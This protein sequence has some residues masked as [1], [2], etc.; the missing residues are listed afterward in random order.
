[1]GDIWRWSAVETARA[2]QMRE[3]SALEVT[4]A[5]LARLDAVNPAINAVVVDLRDSA[6]ARF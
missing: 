2:I 3:V 1:M 6:L 5:H 4:Q